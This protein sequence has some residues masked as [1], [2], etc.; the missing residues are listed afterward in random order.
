[1]RK[2]DVNKLE[3][4]IKVHIIYPL[5]SLII[6]YRV[7]M[8]SSGLIIGLTNGVMIILHSL[9]IMFMKYIPS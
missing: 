4:G 7:G 2:V 8:S 6:E 1:V 5:M 9:M 3:S